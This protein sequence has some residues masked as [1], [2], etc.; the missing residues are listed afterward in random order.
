MNVVKALSGSPELLI[1]D[2]DQG[3]FG[4]TQSKHVALS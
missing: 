1:S 4:V 2:L 3:E